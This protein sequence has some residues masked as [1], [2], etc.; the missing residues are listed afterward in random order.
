MISR[1]PLLL[2]PLLA[3]A[4]FAAPASAPARH[5]TSEA[6]SVSRPSSALD[7]EALVE[8]ESRLELAPNDADLIFACAELALAAEDP[9]SANWYA[10]LARAAADG[11][12]KKKKLVKQIDEFVTLLGVPDTES[13]K[14]LAD[15]AKELFSLA[16][17]CQRRKLYANSVDLLARCTGTRFEREARKKL[18]KLYGNKKAVG[19]L[20][21]SGIDIPEK[22]VTKKD[23]EWIAKEDAKH[24]EW[25]SAYELDDDDTYT[26]ITN[27]GFEL[28][29]TIEAALIQMNGM[30]REAYQYKQRGGGMR[31]AVIQVYA[32][33]E[34]FDNYESQYVDSPSVQ[35]FL[36]PSENRIATYD[37][38]SR[39]GTLADLW[40]TL[41]H[42]ASHQFT[43]AVFPG[44]I[45]AW[46]NE[47]T[48]CFY[49]GCE[50]QASGFVKTNLI[51]EGRLRN[52][53]AMY[54][55]GSPTLEEVVSYH[56]PGSY[57]G[58]YYPWGW[59]LIYFIRNYENEDSERIY[60]P[61]YQDYIKTYKSGG[62]HDVLGRFNEYFV[63]K[64]GVVG[65]DSFESFEKFW[66]EW[67]M[68]L[69]VIHNGGEEQADVLIE[70]ARKQIANGKP[71]Y[72]VPS[73]QWALEKRA[74]DPVAM[75][76][77]AQVQ[78]ELDQ[79]DAAIFELREL[80]Q[81]CRAQ[82]D[83]EQD[84]PGM[85][86]R[87]WAELDGEIVEVLTK[88]DRHVGKGSDEAGRKFAEAALASANSLVEADFPRSAMS[89]LVNANAVLGGD[90]SVGRRIAEL[91]DD[92][93]T[94]ERWRRLDTEIG[95]GRWVASDDWESE[96]EVIQLESSGLVTATYSQALPERYRFEATAR[97]S[98][99]GKTPVV[100]LVFGSNGATG[101]Q[102]FAVL[103]KSGTT[104]T[105]NLDKGNVAKQKVLGPVKGEGE[106]IVLGLEVEG[107][108]VTYFANG[109]K[110]GSR[111]FDAKTVRGEIGLFGQDVEAEYST[112]RVR[113]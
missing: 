50:L 111:R 87:T 72:A 89:L 46:F 75:W 11:D 36:L 84:V 63:D 59:G 57:D 24:S 98:G 100:G 8:A 83:P 41:F 92:G 113:Y 30:F 108:Q 78:L 42:E 31:R 28:A 56:Q 112:L 23:P 44:L 107:T 2:L 25:E 7:E 15:F 17:T 103:T 73:F 93:L 32:T 38:R 61:I 79:D 34:E 47:G 49:E 97:V 58:A 96:G 35:G 66:R 14:L 74:D 64:A 48:A 45:P 104:V 65:V 53:L 16:Q 18:D 12:S 20:L 51:P 55:R 26:V 21:E 68:A 110:V 86:E 80:L 101:T 77:L 43:R 6:V 109:E 62:K 40:G 90:G 3:L 27:T 71:E 85:D 67:I 91:E 81:Q 99:G 102:L 19:A 29:T 106:E 76:E 13:D 9:D 4:G 105:A 94:V 69:G 39:G 37:P 22:P 70:R 88:I 60:W 82:E 33:R 1:S 54:E 10:S 5:S 95:G 52:L